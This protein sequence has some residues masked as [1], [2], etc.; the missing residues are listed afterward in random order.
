MW[1]P[2]NSQDVPA[3]VCGGDITLVTP[4]VVHGW[5]NVPSVDSTK[6]HVGAL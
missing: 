5:A 6:G 3:P 2:V 1:E 4:V